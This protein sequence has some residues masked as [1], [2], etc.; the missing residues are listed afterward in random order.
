MPSDGPCPDTFAGRQTTVTAFQT[1]WAQLGPEARMA[2]NLR[3]DE[4]HERLAHCEVLS[5][6]A[7]EIARE[8]NAM[9]AAVLKRKRPR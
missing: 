9:R 7:G 1:T 3:R 2:Y 5:A 6:E 8:L 4:L